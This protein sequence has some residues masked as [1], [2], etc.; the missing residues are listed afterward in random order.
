MTGAGDLQHDGRQPVPDEIVDVAGDPAP[1]GKQ[2]LLG[3]LVSGRIQL[4]YQLALASGAPAHRPGKD[5]AQSPDPYG[6]FRGILELA[7]QHWRGHQQ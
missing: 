5:D 3:E 7:R 4:R 1:L 2:R 6:D